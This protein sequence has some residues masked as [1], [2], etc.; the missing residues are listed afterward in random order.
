MSLQIREDIQSYVLR[1]CETL[2][3][4]TSII[5]TYGTFG[6]NKS[7][8]LFSRRFDVP[9]TINKQKFDTDIIVK[10][11]IINKLVGVINALE[12]QLLITIANQDALPIET[13]LPIGNLIFI[14]NHTTYKNYKIADYENDYELTEKDYFSQY[15]KISP[16]IPYGHILGFR[17]KHFRYNAKLMVS[18]FESENDYEI[19]LHEHLNFDYQDYSVTVYKIQER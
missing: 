11:S 4:G 6:D 17:G 1:K 16:K 5:R 10:N 9:I 18:V 15:I 3:K 7:E 14:M 8:G 12:L 2:A 13:L 19:H